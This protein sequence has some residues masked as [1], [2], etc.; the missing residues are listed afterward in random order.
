MVR[1]SSNRKCLEDEKMAEDEQ[2]LDFQC[3]DQSIGVLL[4]F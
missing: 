1:T 2:N 4:L 3:Y